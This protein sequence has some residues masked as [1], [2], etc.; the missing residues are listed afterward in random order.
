MKGFILIFAI[1]L[2]PTCSNQEQSKP[3][4]AKESSQENKKDTSL[5]LKFTTGVCS[6]FEDSKGNYWIGSYE[7]GVCEHS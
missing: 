5:K 7:E 6:I 2:Q 1:L 3:S 4:Q